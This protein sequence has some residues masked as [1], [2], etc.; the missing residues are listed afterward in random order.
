SPCKHQAA[1]AIK[2]HERSFN[3]ISALSMDDY[4]TYRYIACKYNLKGTV[5]KDSTFYA[6]LHAL[7]AL[8]NSQITKKAIQYEDLTFKNMSNDND[9]PI[10]DNRP[11]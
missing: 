1:I 5:T 7:I 3:F 10:A 2:Y 6:S 11:I 4:I 8:E 9:V